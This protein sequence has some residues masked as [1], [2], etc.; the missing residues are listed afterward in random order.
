MWLPSIVQSCI[1]S[2]QLTGR[3]SIRYIPASTSLKINKNQISWNV[4]LNT[5]NRLSFNGRFVWNG[6]GTSGNS[7][8]IRLLP[9]KM[10]NVR[11]GMIWSK[12]VA[13]FLLVKAK[14]RRWGNKGNDEAGGRRPRRCFCARRRSIRAAG[15]PRF[16]PQPAESTLVGGKKKKNAGLDASEDLLTQSGTSRSHRPDARRHQFRQKRRT[17]CGI[18]VF[19]F[20][21]PK[22]KLG[23]QVVSS[24]LVAS[25]RASVTVQ[26]S[27]DDSAR[28]RCARRLVCGSR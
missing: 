13:F 2:N 7:P 12:V 23:A 17:F 16:R 9:H 3:N 8:E 24:W 25:W 11:W 27:Q 6:N 14:L 15:T 4:I 18:A 19:A 21:G 20:C 1:R 28:L 22:T 5:R 26:Q 10:W